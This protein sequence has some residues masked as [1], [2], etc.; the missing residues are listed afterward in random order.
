M[1]DKG[2]PN[3]YD[4][5]FKGPVAKRSCT[6][7]L[8][9]IIFIL[10]IIAYILL[11]L[12]AWIHGDPRRVAY[13]TD[14]KGHFCGQKGTSN[15]N[16]TILFYFN[17]FSCTSPSVVVNLQC[18]TTQIC[19]SKC[20]EKFLTYMEIE[21]AHKTSQNYSTY[22]SQFCKTPFGKPAKALAQLLLD[23]DCPTAIFPSKPFLQRC[24]PDFATNNGTLTVG[25]KTTF[26]DG[27]GR[28]RNAIELRTA[29]NR[30]NKI[31]DA[32]A[33]GMKI[34]EDYATTWY[35][36]LI[37]LTIAML[38]SCMFVI[39]LRFIAGILFWVFMVGVIGIIGYGI[40]HCYQEY[41]NLQGRPNSHL[42]VYDLGIQTDLSMYFQLK[43]TWLAFMI[44]LC[45]LEVFIILMLIFLR[46]RIRISI[47]LLKEGS[48]AIG[49]IPT[50]LIYPILT[51]IFISICIAY[52]AVI[53]IY[54]ATSGVPIYKVIAPEGKC[55][56]ENTTCNPEIFNTTEI[57]KACPEAQCNFAFYGGK[58]LYH[59]YVPTF[60]MFNLFVF[61]WLIN[62][63]I[64]LGQCALAGAFASYYWA[65]RKPDD[66]PPHPLFTAFGRAIRYH[67]GSLAF[68]SLLLAL[69]QMFKIVL[70]YLDRRL[71]DPQNNI[72]KF[73][74]C[75]LKCCFWCLE[76]VIK[77]FN[78]N[79]YVMIAIYGKNFCRSA[80]DAF[81]LLMRNILKIAVMDKVTDFVL[82]L[83]KILVAGC[84][85]MLAFLLFT[86]RLP[87]I[88]EG[89]TSLNY[90]WV[91]L[92]TV[93]IGSYLVAHGF[94]SV[95][96]MCIDT[97]FI[98][99]L[100]DLERNDGSTERPYYMSQSLLK[101]L[102]EPTVRT[103]KH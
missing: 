93:I 84:I 57:A 35:W 99:F 91:P 66:I 38:L 29:A 98:C 47:T 49:C 13:P 40:W 97:I 94:F 33:V 72:S 74:Q 30:V 51:F 27:S 96:A 37:G 15:E 92:L 24:F 8:C 77:Y 60:Q 50:T 18:P 10:F 95:Y 39:L 55:K 31:L 6:D 36:I 59:Q 85:G 1:N 70:E 7:V 88:I 62:F 44:I 52:W 5:N 81:N 71:K 22:Y 102:K 46:E 56:H 101:I 89:P 25:N 21:F 76:N 78:R 58:S 20:P 63:V 79:A 90:Y 2:Y 75:C 17:L 68:G 32:R 26:E 3:A 83:G 9:C 28:T 41:N 100:E 64:A 86:Q 48:K 87:T 12:V 82:I 54:L 45:I 34:F 69:I 16:K 42:S 14:S 65:F 23:D 73:L 103:K 11:G 4:P 67:T 80:R 43:Q 19:V 61:F 53:A